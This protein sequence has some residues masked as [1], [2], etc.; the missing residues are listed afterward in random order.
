MEEQKDALG[1]LDLLTVPGFCVKNNQIIKAN[2]AASALFFAEGMD[3]SGIVSSGLEEYLQF[4][5]GCLCLTVEKE[6][7]VWNASVTRQQ[8]ADIFL[9]E[10]DASRSEL[11]ALA[12]AARELRGPLNSTMLMADK[13]LKQEDPDILDSVS[14]LNRGLYQLLR[15]VGNMSDAGYRPAVSQHT[16]HDAATVMR[17]IMQKSQSLCQA[18]GLTL[19]YSGPEEPVYSLC[20]PELLERAVMNILSNAAKFTPKGGAIHAAFTRS[21]NMLRLSIQDSGSGIADNLLR[22]LFYRYLRQSALEDNRYG[23]GLGMV[24]IRSAAIQHGG[25]VLIDQANGGGTRVTLTMAIRQDAPKLSAKILHPISGGY[26]TG[27]IEF[28]EVLPASMYDGTK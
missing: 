15:I 26:D 11:Q 7:I 6:G 5:G 21:G 25:T 18:A 24:L 20:D 10:P 23:I 2:P 19:N 12:L 4:S 16:L 9:L 17:E 13:L 22:T 8:D 3:V 14:R 27:L 1:M 28:S